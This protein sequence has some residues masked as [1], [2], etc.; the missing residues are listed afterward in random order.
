MSDFDPN[1]VDVWR[2]WDMEP[3]TEFDS[4]E[5]GWVAR[6]DYE[7]LLNRYNEIKW[8]YEGLCK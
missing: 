6:E 5:M 3:Y 7:T 2:G 1:K 4:G 8:M